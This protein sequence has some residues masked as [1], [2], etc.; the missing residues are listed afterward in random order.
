MT[1]ALDHWAM[2]VRLEVCVSSTFTCKLRPWVKDVGTHV[3][4]IRSISM[5]NTRIPPP[6][7][8]ACPGACLSSLANMTATADHLEMDVRLEV[9]ACLNFSVFWMPSEAPMPTVI[10]WTLIQN[11]GSGGVA[12]N[13]FGGVSRLPDGRGVGRRAPR[14]RRWTCNPKAPQCLGFRF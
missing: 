2:D 4:P 7:A 1:A 6:L 13:A 12:R 14:N 8:F 9:C 11:S 10:I 3:C 5:A